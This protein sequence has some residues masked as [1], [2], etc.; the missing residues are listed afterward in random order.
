[1][2]KIQRRVFVNRCL[3]KKQLALTTMKNIGMRKIIITPRCLINKE[4]TNTVL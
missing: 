2:E 4:I 1:M 3:L